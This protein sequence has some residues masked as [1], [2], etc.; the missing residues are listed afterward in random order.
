M[1]DLIQR[2]SCILLAGIFVAC[3][4]SPGDQE[5]LEASKFATKIFTECAEEFSAATE[6]KQCSEILKRYTIR[7]KKEVTPLR[8][9]A[10]NQAKLHPEMSLNERFAK[11]YPKEFHEFKESFLRIHNLGKQKSSMCK[12]DPEYLKVQERAWRVFLGL[13]KPL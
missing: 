11:K 4:K 13:E 6:P 12:A 2:V 8:E 3:V 5:L 1:K 9:S 7:W 10:L